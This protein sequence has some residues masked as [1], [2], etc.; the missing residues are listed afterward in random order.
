MIYK[1]LN[2][3]GIC[4][5]AFLW[6]APF[7][8]SRAPQ[9]RFKEIGPIVV[10]VRRTQGQLEYGLDDM[11]Y[12]KRDLNFQLAELKLASQD[13]PRRVLV[14]LDDST[15]LSDLSLVPKM[16]IDAGFTDIQ[17]FAVWPKTGNMAEVV[18]GPVKKISRDP[19]VLEGERR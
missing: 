3:V 16:A 2:V 5:V 10:N 7:A 8:V 17:V 15:Y 9:S 18:F 14:M 12:S 4:F 1:P 13:T 11:K 6:L 19:R